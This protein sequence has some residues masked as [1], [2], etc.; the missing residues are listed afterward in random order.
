MQ[1]VLVSHNKKKI[2]ELRA[3]LSAV[4]PELT[5]L[6]AGEAG[7]P[8]DI[9]EDGLTFA[10][11][12]PI[13]AR[14]AAERGYI[15]IADDS[16]LT[17]DALDGAPGV[18]SARYAG[19]HG[20]DAANNEKLLRELAC[21]PDQPRTAAFVC[22]M[23]CVFPDGESFTCEGRC[24]GEI[25]TAPRGEGG[26]GYDPLFLYVPAGKSFA[27]LDGE[28]KNKI[29]HRARALSAFAPELARRMAGRTHEN[30]EKGKNYVNK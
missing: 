20:D 4:A 19:E 17:V 16:G 30:S 24:P 21:R 26:F 13:K 25:L 15:G 22:T 12:A 10:E 1:A 28:E 29:S 2:A 6:S 11:N 7:L 9:P 14:A 3:I 23:A 27:E 8:D 5:L 18:Y